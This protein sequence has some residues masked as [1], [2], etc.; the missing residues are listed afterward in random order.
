VNRSK[1]GSLG[2][3]LDSDDAIS[4]SYEACICEEAHANR[5]GTGQLF[6]LL[7]CPLPPIRKHQGCKKPH[8]AS[9]IGLRPPGRGHPQTC[10]IHLAIGTSVFITLTIQRCSSISFGVGREAG[11]R[12]S[13]KH[14]FRRLQWKSRQRGAGFWNPRFF[15]EIFHRATPL[16]LLLIF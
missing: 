14:N 6:S 13:L 3:G 4:S 2:R 7:L 11:S 10:A 1:L 8:S 5:W 15:D 9:Y 12:V 16:H